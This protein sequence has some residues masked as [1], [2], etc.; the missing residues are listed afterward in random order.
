MAQFGPPP[1]APPNGPAPVLQSR[2]EIR[3]SGSL[4]TGQATATPL[5]L[6]LRDAIRRG[7]KYNL[8]ILTSHDLADVAKAER[9]RTLS[10]LLPGISAAAI[11]TSGQNDLAAFGFGG[12]PGFPAVVGPFGT[13]NIRVYAQQTVYDRPSLRNLKSASESQKAAALSADD[14]RNLVV[15][16]VSNA[17]LAVITDTARAQAIQAEITTAQAL[18]DRANDQKNAGTVAGIDVLRAR[19]QLRTEQQR[20]VA[21]N[22]QIEKDKLSLARAIGLP[23]GQTFNVTDAFPFAPLETSRES[24]VKQA[25]SQRPDFRA[26]EAN[27]RAAEFALQSAQS[28]HWP[29]VVVQADYGDIGSNFAH[30]HGTYDFT[31]GVKVPIYAGGRTKTD[32]DQAE[33]VLRNRRNEVE[34]LR[35]RIDFEVRSALLDL[36][37]AAQQVDVAKESVGLAT[38]TL[39]QARD[40][41]S[42]GVTDNIEVIEA[43]QA[44]ALAN[45]NYIASLGQHNSAKIALATALGTA[46]ETVPA[47][48]GLK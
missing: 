1:A 8:G 23:T 35:G 22:S 33:A 48:L 18:Y 20:L 31:A 19:L 47:Y 45:E 15:E 4:P 27:V 38:E 32:V 29:S 43:Q 46:E 2:P 39:S 24:L 25:T 21:Q 10:T 34:G 41:F 3:F 6:T 44:L 26:A 9:Q 37:S 5:D 16:A 42:A 36:E 13:E 30:S 28:Q 7:L 17:Y 12:V 40:R 14:T 11:Q